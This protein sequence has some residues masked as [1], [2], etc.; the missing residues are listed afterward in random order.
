[1][2]KYE[3]E[4]LCDFATTDLETINVKAGEK[5][6]ASEFNVASFIKRGLVRRVKEKKPKKVEE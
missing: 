4:A 1:M 3:V 5:F 2:K 6:Y